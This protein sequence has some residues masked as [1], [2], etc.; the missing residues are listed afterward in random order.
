MILS[1]KS[2]HLQKHENLSLVPKNSIKTLGTVAHACNLSAGEVETGKSLGV[3]TSQ[4]SLL[5]FTCEE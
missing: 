1:V 5:T 2:S 4:P 3:L